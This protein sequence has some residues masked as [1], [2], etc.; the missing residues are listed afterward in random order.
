MNPTIIL[1]EIRYRFSTSSGKGGQH[2]N[3]VNTKVL[4]CWNLPASKGLSDE[5]KDLLSKN[6]S[7]EINEL[8]EICITSQ[9][10][11]SQLKNRQDADEKLL[12]LLQKGLIVPKKRKKT[13]VPK[14]VKEEIRRQKKLKSALKESRKK[15]QRTFLSD[16]D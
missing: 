15:I 8:G 4:A 7:K 9:L 5:E 11:R 16:K 3:K 2:V 6:L 1:S 13:K 12:L 10:T 14:E